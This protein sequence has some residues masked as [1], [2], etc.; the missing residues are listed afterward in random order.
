VLAGESALAS[1]ELAGRARGC[2]AGWCCA[3]LHL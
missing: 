1:G 2:L 3:A